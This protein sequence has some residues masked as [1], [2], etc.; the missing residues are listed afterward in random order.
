MK[1]GRV[2]KAG[3]KGVQSRGRKG[4]GKGRGKV[5]RGPRRDDDETDPNS[6]RGRMSAKLAMD[7]M[8]AMLNPL[9]AKLDGMK[10]EIDLLKPRYIDVH[11]HT[12]SHTQFMSHT[13]A[14][15]PLQVTSRR[16]RPKHSPLPQNNVQLLPKQV[17]NQPHLMI[18]WKPKIGG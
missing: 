8:Q 3:K 15:T 1:R 12:H 9:L 16:P 18:S 5:T 2:V 17:L 13:P 7:Q 4:K 11:S 10:S 14:M 6:K